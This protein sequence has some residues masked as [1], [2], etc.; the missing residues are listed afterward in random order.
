MYS[1]PIQ[2]EYA[3]LAQQYDRRWSFYVNATVEE[4]LYIYEIQY[5]PTN[6]SA[7]NM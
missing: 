1:D 7:L 5:E 3:R 4:T 2:T 6:P